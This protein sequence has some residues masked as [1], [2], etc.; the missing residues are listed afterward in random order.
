TSCCAT[1]RARSC[2]SSSSCSR[3]RATARRCP[4]AGRHGSRSTSAPTRAARCAPRRCPRKPNP[5]AWWPAREAAEGADWT[6]EPQP[7][8]TRTMNRHLLTLSLLFLAAGCSS[9]QYGDP[10][11]PETLNVDWGSTDLQITTGKMVKSL[12]E[13]PQLAYMADPSKGQD[14]RI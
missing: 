3:T 10:K 9:T 2:A 14:Q 13:A 7:R 5:G 8:M 1:A 6:I 4:T 11:D 12:L